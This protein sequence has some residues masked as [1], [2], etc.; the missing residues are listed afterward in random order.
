MSLNCHAV[1]LAAGVILKEEKKALSCGGETVWEAFEETR[2]IASQKMS[3]DS[4]ETVIAPRRQDVSQGLWVCNLPL[5]RPKTDHDT[6]TWS[7][8]CKPVS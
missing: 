2:V 5:P 3:R 8:S 7:L 6:E 1:A 4:G